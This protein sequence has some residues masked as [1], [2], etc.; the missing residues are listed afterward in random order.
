MNTVEYI[1]VLEEGVDYDQVWHDIESFTIGLPFVPDRVPDI[2]D[3]RT[4][5][6]RICHYMLTDAEAT[7]LQN[8]PRVLAVERPPDVSVVIRAN[9]V[10]NFD[11]PIS[12]NTSYVNWALLRCTSS[13]NNYGTSTHAT[14]DYTY[15][16]D[17]TGVDVVIL[18]TGIQ[19]D[20]PEFN[21]AA[22]I[23]RVQKIDW[24]AASN[25]AV[26]GTFS[27]AHYVD[28]VGH[29]TH[30]AGIV[31]GMT[32][33]WAKNA[34]IYSIK[35]VDLQGTSTGGL[36]VTQAFDVLTAWHLAK[37][38]NPITGV[39]QPTIANMSFGYDSSTFTNIVSGQY[40]GTNWAAQTAQP[41]KGMIGQTFGARYSSV[42]T[43]IKT[44][45][46]A[47]I[48][49]CIAAGNAS[50]KIDIPTGTDYNNYFI[51][52]SGYTQYYHRG[53]SPFSA[54]A[55][56]VGNVTTAT[57]NATTDQKAIS[58]NAGPGV[59][60]YAPGTAI[61]SCT[62][63]ITATTISKLLYYADPSF[64]QALL[65][66]TST[67]SPQVCGVVALFLQMEPTLSTDKLKDKILKNSI[68][69]VYTTG[70]DN[71]YSNTRSIV[72][73]TPRLLYTPYSSET[74]LRTAGSLTFQ[75]I[76]VINT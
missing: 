1:V 25:G 19:A 14:G 10:G 46:D 44:M 56:S 57:H 32:Y 50:Q 48:H 53:G 11:K 42:D 40:R 31:A 66:G 12:N 39:K 49:V 17:G 43:A 21:N 6:P 9:Q 58:S 71:D 63:S 72:G 18:D 61:M 59:D 68:L 65:S 62:S 29:G 60:I 41:A 27:P 33:G 3:N 45:T 55:I 51:N 37:P 15:T 26:L 5:M 8:D 67:A 64:S 13:I 54:A 69:T 47:G 16:L 7:K 52:A 35:L 38:I 2:A 70:L 76:N 24:F 75:D 22:G 4:I 30:V 34:N 74:I 23:S 73:G 28:V 20:H 36:T